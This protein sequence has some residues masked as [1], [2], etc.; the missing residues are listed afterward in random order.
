MSRPQVASLWPDEEPGQGPGDAISTLGP[1]CAAWEHM[2][3]AE[4]G[5]QGQPPD[6][7]PVEWKPRLAA[8]GWAKSQPGLPEAQQLCSP[9]PREQSLFLL[10]PSLWDTGSPCPSEPAGLSHWGRC[11]MPPTCSGCYPPF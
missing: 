4:P 2:A 9:A 5:G 3:L 7:G 1:G 8:Q 11:S 6:K 10:S